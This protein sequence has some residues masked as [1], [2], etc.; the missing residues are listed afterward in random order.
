VGLTDVQDGGVNLATK[1]TWTIWWAGIIFTFFLVGRV[2]CVACPFGALNEWTARLAGPLRRAARA[3]PDRLGGPPPVRPADLGRR[4]AGRGALAPGDGLDPP[5][6]RGAGDRGRALL[7]APELLPAPLPD[8]R[9][10]RDLFDDRPGGA[11]RQ[12]DRAVRGRPDQG[13]LS[14]QRGGARLSDV[15]VPGQ[16]RP[17]QLLHALPAVRHHVLSREPEPPPP[18]L[19]TGSL[20]C[21]APAPRRGLPRRRPG[22]SHALGDRA[23]A[24]RLVGLGLGAR[25]L[26]AST[27]AGEPSAGDLPGARRVDPPPRRGPGAGA[28]PGAGR[29]GA[30]RLAGRRAPAGCA[31]D[32]RR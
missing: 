26:A 18:R 15:R 16:P 6:L 25:P 32:V 27:G 5:G 1:L 9:P 7:R 24:G 12:G 21:Q 20:D 22:G 11:P 13:V 4:A 3:G 8:R 28:P 2:W 10:H 23:D 19:R 31:P 14:R 17:Q 30:G 29:G